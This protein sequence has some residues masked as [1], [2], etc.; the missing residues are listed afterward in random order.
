METILNE[1][2]KIDGENRKAVFHDITLDFP[3]GYTCMGRRDDVNHIAFGK[4][5]NTI[6]VLWL[7]P[8]IVEEVE[9]AKHI[10]EEWV[11]GSPKAIE[12]D[13]NGYRA[14]FST[15]DVLRNEQDQ[16][17]WPDYT[18]DMVVYNYLIQISNANLMFNYRIPALFE[19]NGLFDE[20][21][22][23]KMMIIQSSTQYI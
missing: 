8:V 23:S 20:E 14:W 9:E 13:I 17:F 21:H 5:P 22:E 12:M 15:E 10:F 1:F 11:K 3:E 2:L 16:F 4:Y 7:T 6:G 19:D 18:G